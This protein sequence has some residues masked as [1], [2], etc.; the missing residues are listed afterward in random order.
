MVIQPLCVV[1]LAGKIGN[2]DIDMRVENDQGLVNGLSLLDKFRV[3]RRIL[4]QNNGVWP[5]ENHDSAA[6]KRDDLEK[7]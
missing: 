5:S 2:G 7:E 3:D 6:D 4:C 1:P